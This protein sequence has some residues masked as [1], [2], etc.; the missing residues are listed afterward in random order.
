MKVTIKNIYYFSSLL[1]LLIMSIF[2]CSYEKGILVSEEAFEAKLNNE[3]VYKRIVYKSEEIYVDGYFVY[4]GDI[5]QKLPVLI[6]NRGGLGEIGSLSDYKAINELTMYAKEGYAVLASNYRGYDNKYKDEYGGNDL[7]DVLNMIELVKE[8]DYLDE[9]NIQMLGVSRGGLMTYMSL[10]E[11]DEIKSA[12]I[13]SGMTDF[14]KLYNDRGDNM[15]KQYSDAIGGTPEEFP[16][17]YLKRSPI[18]WADEIEAPILIIHGEKDIVVKV[19]H[20]YEMSEKL[21]ALK[22]EH[23]LLIFSD[24]NH[25]ILSNK[26]EMNVKILEWLAINSH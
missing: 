15:Q 12:I 19:S 6:Y 11:S 22:K 4:P 5:N 3:I 23:E 16:D 1:I 25:G 7:N 18:L 8:I 14:I 21:D 2:G 20:A 13:I 10:R 17:K 24:D 9:D 26:N